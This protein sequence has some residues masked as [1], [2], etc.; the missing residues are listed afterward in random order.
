MLSES[1]E[2]VY[3]SLL[4]GEIPSLWLL[5]SYP[6]LKNVASY[7]KDL[8]LRI[9]TYQQW[10]NQ[11][12][13]PSIFWISGFFFTQSFLTGVFQNYARKYKIEIDTLTFD[14]EFL[15]ED[16]TDYENEIYTSNSKKSRAPEDGA[17]ISGLFLEGARWDYKKQSLAESQP[18][19]LF[20]KVPIIWLKPTSVS[21]MKESE[22]YECPLYKTA[23][24]KGI[25]TTTG[26][27]TNF[28]MNAKMP[29]GDKPSS[30]WVKR[31]VAMIC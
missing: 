16:P 7:I 5:Q 25:L 17:L 13:P 12:S 10:I 11:G 24:R 27:S 6:S 22:V 26:H 21:K 31:G 3:N 1:L 2:K 19:I 28:I 8:V 15:E 29:Q 4:I 20:S 18:K 9:Q 30:H 14:F 23:E